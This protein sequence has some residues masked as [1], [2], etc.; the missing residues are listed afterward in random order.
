MD[1]GGSSGFCWTIEDNRVGTRHHSDGD[2]EGHGGCRVLH[3]NGIRGH[4]GRRQ[5]GEVVVVERRGRVGDARDVPY[6]VRVWCVVCVST[7]ANLRQAG[8]SHA[9]TH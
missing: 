3:R 2:L 7:R 1:Q 5:R 9:E 4:D 6:T 8:M